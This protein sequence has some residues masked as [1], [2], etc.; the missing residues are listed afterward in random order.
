[1]SQNATLAIAPPEGTA[2]ALRSAMVAEYGTREE[3]RVTMANVR[4]AVQSAFVARAL[5]I[6]AVQPNV[7]G[8]K[9]FAAEFDG[10]V[11][12]CLPD[13]PNGGSKA[14]LARWQERRDSAVKRGRDRFKS[15][16]SRWTTSKASKAPRAWRLRAAPVA[17]VSS[18]RDE[19]MAM[20]MAEHGSPESGD[21][22]VQEAF[23]YRTLVQVAES[24]RASQE[25]FEASCKDAEKARKAESAKRISE[26]NATRGDIA[27]MVTA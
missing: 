8:R 1:M 14:D 11:L 7:E 5:E 6:A 18:F 20:C 12:A 2:M 17:R 23:C 4:H 15:L 9:A 26:T 21:L 13:P 10:N 19:I 25:A 27:A 3:T 22:T 24:F 16:L